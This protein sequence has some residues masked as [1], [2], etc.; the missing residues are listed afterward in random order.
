MSAS[1]RSQVTRMIGIGALAGLAF[2]AVGDGG[3]QGAAPMGI[4]PL[5]ILDLQVKNNVLFVLDTSGS[6]KAPVDREAQFPIG[7]DDPM[8]R[9][10][11]AKQALKTVIQNNLGKLN[12]G[13]ASYNV[14]TSQSALNSTLDLD[15]DRGGGDADPNEVITTAF[16]LDNGDGPFVYVSAD[17]NAANPFYQSFTC[18][19][20]G[21]QNVDGF[22]CR[23]TNVF[24]DWD[25]ANSADVFRS[26]YN[27]SGNG[28]GQS[29]VDDPYPA[30][31]TAFDPLTSTS[32]Q[33]TNC[34]FYLESRLFR[35]NKR[36][37]WDL[38]SNNIDTRL[39]STADIACPLPP[40]GLTGE[41]PDTNGDGLGDN[42]RPCIE[43]VDQATGA[44]ARFYYTSALFQR[45]SAFDSCGGAAILTTVSNCVGDNSQA[46]LDLMKPEI[47]V[48]NDVTLTVGMQANFGTDFRGFNP[49][50]GGLRATQNTPIA[51]A[52]NDIR[53]ANPAAF[54]ARPP[55]VDAVQRN[56]V[57]FLTDGDDTCA[58]PSDP[59][60][61]ANAA[62]S[63]ASALYY[64]GGGPGA[65]NTDS[66]HQA[67]LFFV[68]FTADVDVTRANKIARAGSGGIVSNGNVTCPS[69][70]PCRDAFTATST[71]DLVKALQ[72]ALQFSV[73]GG[74]FAA[75]GPTIAT[76]FELSVDDPATPPPAIEDAFHP[77]WD[78][79]CTLNRYSHR[80]NTFFQ[81]TFDM[82]GFKGHIFAFNNT[83]FTAVQTPKGVNVNQPW[84][85]GAALNRQVTVNLQTGTGSG[86]QNRFT[87]AELHAGASVENIG[88][89]NARI[90]RRIF[91]SDGNGRF[92]RSADNQFDSADPA[93][94]NVVSIWPPNQ[95][96]VTN[97]KGDVDPAVGTP[98]PLDAALGISTMTFAELQATFHAC[99]S[100]TDA[101]AGP[102]PAGCAPADPT[103]SLNTALKEAREAILAYT[104]G[105]KLVIG[106]DS[107]P[108]RASS[109]ELL[110]RDRD[111]ILN[112]STLSQPAV[113]TPPLRA[114]PGV[115]VREFLLFRDGRRDANRNGIAEVNLGFG[116]RNP[117]IDD[118]SPETKLDLKPVM[119]VL[120]IGS[121][122]MLHA[123]KAETG[124]EL[125]GF[126]PFD[127][128]GKLKD[129]MKP[130][131]RGN[132]AY[133]IST[134]PRVANIFVPGTFSASNVT[135]DGR[136]RTIVAVGRGAGGKFLSVLDVTGPG[137]FTKE[138]L[139]ANLPW[140]MM[141]RGNPDTVDGT[142]GG[143]QVRAADFASY[144]KM[145]Q[146]WSV[147]AVGNVD[148]APSP[149]PSPS[150]V[151]PP[152]G[153]TGGEWRLFMGSGYGDTA[154]EGSTFF[155][156]DPITGDIIDARDVGDGTPTY[157]PDNALVA[158][159]AAYNP[160]QLD[161]PSQPNRSEDHTT[162]V[163]IPDIHGRIWKFAAGSM[164]K[165]AD[166][167][168]SQPFGDAVAL[169]KLADV[170]HVF[171]SS[172]HDNRVAVP[173]QPT[174]PFKMFAYRDEGGDTAISPGVPPLTT[175]GPATAFP[176]SFPQQFHSE[177]QPATFFNEV[178]NGR[179]LYS[180]TQF[181][182]PD[183]TCLSSFDTILFAVG[184]TSGQAVY[185][186]GTGSYSQSKIFTGN[187]GGVQAQGGEVIVTDSGAPGRPPAPPSPHPTP[188]PYGE[189]PPKVITVSQAAGTPVCRQ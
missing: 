144:A 123:F 59:N 154:Q 19:N 106:N 105:A 45:N 161:I 55:Q 88:T 27:R 60:A 37:T 149:M 163:F 75:S 30:G 11:Q 28:A 175:S 110:Y 135:F 56:Y 121:N 183:I 146:T 120:Y 67:E 64:Q 40:V 153:F 133:V 26:F 47:P 174:P 117:D 61:S 159:A 187:K 83:S 76:V 167:G 78:A 116:L 176:I 21:N 9:M 184:A 73:A 158:N 145:G 148:V 16:S 35:S 58:N 189:Q 93:G 185:D 95:D 188:K 12:F 126:V 137:P 22:W 74:S 151:A 4:D 177:S 31:C 1:R 115:H 143:T 134:S 131:T 118:A 170:G 181:H 13:V 46:I 29:R 160:F 162:R 112:D 97:T 99:Q 44:I 138:A 155:V 34:H 7:P 18:P 48:A 43:M 92:P 53:V 63:A 17:F 152:G 98:G 32:V 24:A 41:N 100:S 104:A 82:P 127:Q 57:I 10:Y 180:G 90:K 72:E 81:P 94:R 23:T 85:A 51:K 139:D 140:V 52:L 125:W 186:Y 8:S 69:G 39:V 5:E 147:P 128:L 71:D 109:G 103:L 150:P 136:W 166:E 14:L 173:A 132:H 77:C 179:V 25:G 108:F 165:F 122:S 87:F 68:A 65:N 178:G 20:D 3:V 171:A 80:V 54:P 156:L 164:G 157:F 111:W 70:V 6:M 172:G 50:A 84:D 89:T 96:K 113:V 66:Q 168:P 2:L 107:K 169:L 102:L 36:Y 33:G 91:T 130:Q 119:T 142:A 42:P 129:L 79:G 114:V 62:A 141:N 86:G 38:T 15:N 182:P 124:E 49:P 101:G